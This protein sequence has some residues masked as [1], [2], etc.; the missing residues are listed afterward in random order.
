MEHHTVCDVPDWE[1]AG[2]CESMGRHAAKLE[3]CPFLL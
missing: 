1:V 3:L 2:G